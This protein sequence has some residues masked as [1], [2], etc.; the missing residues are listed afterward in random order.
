MRGRDKICLFTIDLSSSV[1]SSL[2][3]IFVCTLVLSLQTV[4][5]CTRQGGG[6]CNIDGNT[7]G[8]F[9]FVAANVIETLDRESPQLFQL[10][11]GRS[12]WFRLWWGHMKLSPWWAGLLFFHA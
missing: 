4:P 6:A 3:L 2:S 8:T 10:E 12:M 7:G 5:L 1:M 9:K 11:G